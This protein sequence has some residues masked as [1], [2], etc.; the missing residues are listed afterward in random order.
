MVMSPTGTKSNSQDILQRKESLHS[1]ETFTLIQKGWKS[2][3]IFPQKSQIDFYMFWKRKEAI[4]STEKFCNCLEV[5]KIDSYPFPLRLEI[6]FMLLTLIR[7][8][9]ISHYVFEVILKF[10]NRLLFFHTTFMKWFWIS[11]I[12]SFPYVFQIT[13]DFL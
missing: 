12:G 11:K 7:S 8:K 13:F 9:S 5:E 4:Y 6:D 1:I 3:S 10:K 2:I